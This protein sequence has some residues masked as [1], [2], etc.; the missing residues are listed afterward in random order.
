[1]SHAPALPPEVHEAVRTLANADRLLVAS[2]FDGTMAPIVENPADAAPLP[3]TEAALSALAALPRTVV[4]V[5]SGRSLAVLTQ[6]TDLPE[7]VHLIGSHGA[8]L[9]GSFATGMTADERARLAE[10][11]RRAH[12][13]AERFLGIEVEQKP[14]STAIHYRHVPDD[15]RPRAIEAIQAGACDVDGVHV[16][17][18]K[19]VVEVAALPT[20]KGIALD[21]LRRQQNATAVVFV[22][23]DVTDED[24]FTR[25]AE[26]DV[27]VKVGEGQ[28]AATHRI[29][30]TAAVAHL[31]TELARARSEFV[32]E[33]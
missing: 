28:T 4:A 25:L 12:E 3:A 1:M 6:L 24:A 27:A 33:S 11:N 15:D 10:I 9:D 26:P 2:D 23:D 31:L 22:G 29:A 20:S 14:A 18:G 5:I 17:T 8:E 13:V 32:R 21:R 16:T 30:D 7:S 19:M